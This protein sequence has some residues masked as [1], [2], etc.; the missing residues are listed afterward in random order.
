MTPIQSLPIGLAIFLS[1]LGA[2]AGYSESVQSPDGQIR[3]EVGL[4]QGQ[5][6][7]QVSRAGRSIIKRSGLGLTVTTDEATPQNKTP[8]WTLTQTESRDFDQTWQPVVGKR[9]TVRNHYREL[10]ISLQCEAAHPQTRLIQFRVYDEGVAFRYDVPADADGPTSVRFADDQSQVALTGDHQVWSYRHE[11]R[12]FGPEPVSK[13]QGA[14]GYPVVMQSDAGYWLAIT[15]ANLTGMDFFDVRFPGDSQTLEI[16]IDSSAVTLP[17]RTP[18]RVIMISDNP[19]DFVNSDMLVN[20]SPPPQGDFSWVQ[21][22]LSLWDWRVWG[23]K[24]KDGFTYEMGFESWKRLIDFAAEK[25]I[26][27]LLL[28]ANWYGPEH[29]NLS[30]PFKGGMAA[31]VKQALDYGKANDVGL[32]LYLNDAASK[33]F[34]I[35]DIVEAYGRWGAVG[36]KYGFM[37]G[38]HQEKVLKT[39]RIVK[40]C[41]ANKLFVNFHDGPIPPTGHE[42]PW[43]HWNTREYVHAQTDA[44]RTHLPGDFVHMAYVNTITGPIDGNHGLFDYETPGPERPPQFGGLYSTIVAECA[45]TLILYSGLTVLPD[46]PEAYRAHPKLFDFIASQKQPWKQSRI[47]G[48]EFGKWISIMRQATD[49]TWLVATATDED[50]RTVTIPL[51][52]LPEGDY[53]AIL[54]SDAKD[55]HYKTNRVAYDITTQKV[56]AKTTIQAVLAPGGGHAMQIKPIQ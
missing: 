37:K 49:G 30:D 1:V 50:G 31:Q 54:Y 9:E 38:A 4:D 23:Y 14:R 35:E 18:W 26:P 3:V 20:L 25:D 5:P 47:L 32:I 24:T 10:S 44:H 28:D 34:V 16:H 33:N 42:R 43:P 51:D 2:R 45:R 55:A 29:S 48:G 40:A 56:N 52:F 8:Q 53:Q 39:E 17:F 21:P 15:E 13:I 41:A 22:G 12:P 7:Y 6:W 27:Y 36:I 11:R 46:A 19:S